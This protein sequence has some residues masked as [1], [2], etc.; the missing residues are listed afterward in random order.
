M[1]HC[2]VVMVVKIVVGVTMVD[3]SC[4]LFMVVNGESLF[5][6]NNNG[7]PWLQTPTTRVG[8]TVT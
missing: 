8:F 7:Q 6:V 5:M 4:N 1:E 3:D 2:I